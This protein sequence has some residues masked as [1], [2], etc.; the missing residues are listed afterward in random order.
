MNIRYLMW[1]ISD[2]L[3]L[4]A[5]VCECDLNIIISLLD[6]MVCEFI[7]VWLVKVIHQSESSLTLKKIQ[8]CSRQSSE[9]WVKWAKSEKENKNKY[10]RT[11]QEMEQVRESANETN[12]ANKWI[13]NNDNNWVSCAFVACACF[14]YLL[15]NALFSITHSGGNQ[16]S[17]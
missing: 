13:Y 6:A 7:F 14:L 8:F 12:K 16:I 3:S 15:H 4:C 9:A 1:F 2:P 11:R 5:C 17:T 10:T